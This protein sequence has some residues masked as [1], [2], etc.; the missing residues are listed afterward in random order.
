MN[1]HPTALITRAPEDA[2]ALQTPLQRKGYH[3]V[4]VPLLQRRPVDGA[5]ASI[6]TARPWRWVLLTSP[7]TVRVCADLIRRHGWPCA[8][9]G[10]ATARAARAAGLDLQ[11]QAPRST[12]ED[13]VR[14]LGEIR[15]IPLLYPCAEEATPSTLLALRAAGA[16]VD[17]VAVYRN[18]WPPDAEE[19]L[20]SLGAVDVAPLLSG[21]AARRLGHAVEQGWLP[22]PGWIGVIGPSTAA[23]AERSGLRVDFV[24][25]P[26]GLAALLDGVPPTRR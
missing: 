8:A 5:L 21:S 19:R 4:C 13:L 18:E 17:R 1:H 9:V 7:Y 3:T 25:D 11:L 2:G 24:A 20:R 26:P 15:G 10:P 23:E 14:V 22:H 12:G 16:D 6:D